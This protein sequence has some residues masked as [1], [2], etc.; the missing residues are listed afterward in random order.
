VDG[1]QQMVL[2]VE[3]RF[4]ATIALDVGLRLRV[5]ILQRLLSGI[6]SSQEYPFS[7]LQV[8]RTLQMTVLRHQLDS[9]QEILLKR[10]KIVLN[11]FSSINALH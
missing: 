9:V 11:R 7:L 8:R 2:N 5:R 10:L 6:M 1:E 4:A 3:D